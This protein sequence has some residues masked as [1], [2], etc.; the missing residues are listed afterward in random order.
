MSH[1]NPPC[2]VDAETNQIVDIFKPGELTPD[3]VSALQ[4][5]YGTTFLVLPYV[6]A[7]NRIEAPF[8]TPPFEITAEHFHDMLTL[9]PPLNRC[10]TGDAESFKSMEMIAGDI[11]DI[12]VRIR[13]R[14]FAFSDHRDT[15]HEECC[16]RVCESPA[17][18]LDPEYD[19]R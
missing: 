17:F 3:R 1:D 15:P 8:I 19:Q 2:L 18:S 13:R 6:D 4:K 12:Y 11:T 5:Q 14:Y 7:R 16:R 9:M 10:N